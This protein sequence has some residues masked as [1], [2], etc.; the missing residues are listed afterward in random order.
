L[1]FFLLELCKISQTVSLLSQPMSYEL[2]SIEWVKSCRK[3]AW[4]SQH[5]PV[6]HPKN[7]VLGFHGW[8]E[9]VPQGSVSL[10]GQY[11]FFFWSFF[12][13]ANFYS[14]GQ[15]FFWP[16]PESKFFLGKLLPTPNLPITPL[17]TNPPPSLMLLTPPHPTI[18]AHFQRPLVLFSPSPSLDKWAP[19]SPA[20]EELRSKARQA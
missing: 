18:C 3:L 2:L 1:L 12:V 15:F 20:Q 14:L 10:P 11:F 7:P 17:P 13:Q 5:P 9:T 6:H 8:D 4:V 19:P 16:T